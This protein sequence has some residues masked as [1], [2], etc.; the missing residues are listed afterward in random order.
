MHP[1]LTSSELSVHPAQYQINIVIGRIRSIVP[2]EK[3]RKVFQVRD[4]NKSYRI[5]GRV[6]RAHRK[7][8]AIMVVHEIKTMSLI[9]IGE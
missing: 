2:K 8:K 9:I 1:Y 6:P 3:G 7:V 5:R 4:I